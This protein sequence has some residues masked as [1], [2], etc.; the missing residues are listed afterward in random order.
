MITALGLLC[1]ATPAFSQ[2][3]RTTSDTREFISTPVAPPTPLL[4]YH[5][6]YSYKDRRPG[7]AVLK[8][9][10]ATELLGDTLIRQIFDASDALD[11]KS[12]KFK[13]LAQNLNAPGT[14][15]LLDLGA[16]CDQCDWEAPV[17]EQGIAAML[18]YL[19]NMRAMGQLV[20]VHAVLLASNGD[21]DGALATLRLGYGL[22][23]A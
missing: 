22:G 18:P 6:L 5:F 7:N 13:S 4:K 19:N 3:T 21:V 11:E 15:A 14:L 12:P 20:R 17:R 16:R 1:L 8:Y 23:R 2:T 10:T 9:T